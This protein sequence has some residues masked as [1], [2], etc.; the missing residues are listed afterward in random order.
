MEKG[1]VTISI[2][3]FFITIVLVSLTFI[4]VRTVEETNSIGIEKMREDE[5]RQ[6]VLN[7]KNKYSEVEEKININNQKIQEYSDTIQNNKQ[8]SELLDKELEEYNML[9]GKT[10]VTGDGVVLKLY[11]SNEQLYSASNLVYLVNEL[12]YSGAEAIS[13]N[14]QRVINST[15]IVG[16]NGNQYILVNGERIVSPYEIK[17]IGNQ[18]EMDKILNFPNEGF[19]PYYQS[20]GY[21]IEIDFQSNVNIKGYDKQIALKYLKEK[22]E[23]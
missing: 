21:K 13:I 16:I 23:E 6:E 22:K 2:I 10:D 3:V 11:D 15:D 5:L 19:V 12:K 18:S 17:A 1:K 14:N 20:K 7:W 8:S 4:Q 9:V